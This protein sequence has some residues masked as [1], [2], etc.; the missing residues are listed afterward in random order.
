MKK[1][2]T[3]LLTLLAILTLLFNF[4]ACLDPEIPSAQPSDPPSSDSPVDDLS[5][6]A[7]YCR[8]GYPESL[9]PLAV[10]VI[11]TRWELDVYL[12]TFPSPDAQTF[13]RYDEAYFAERD[14]II[15]F[16][17]EGSSSI[18][19]KVNQ[20]S[21]DDTTGEWTI[22]IEQL[23]PEVG[24]DDEA[25]WNIFIEPPKNMRVQEGD[26]FKIYDHILSPVPL[27]TF[28]YHWGGVQYVRTNGHAPDTEF[29]YSLIIRSKQ[30]LLNYYEQNRGYYNMDSTWDESP[31]FRDAIGR[32]DDTYFKDR[33]LLIVVMEEPSGSIR[34]KVNCMWDVF[35]EG[36][37]VYKISITS[38][39]SMRGDDDMAQWHILIELPEWFH[40]DPGQEIPLVF[41]ER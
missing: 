4:T 39:T 18:R 24:T 25:E 29:P 32:Y 36:E 2:L 40:T 7:Q 10:T 33:E 1:I 30:E 38:F 27:D 13:E 12:D 17:A 37:R 31:A 26:T 3:S 6:S 34:H 11:R 5:F 20:V 19:H 41:K 16:V 15:S 35:I 28:G 21:R 23:I 9:G 8:A 14:L 22:D